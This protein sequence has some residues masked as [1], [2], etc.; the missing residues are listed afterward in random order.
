MNRRPALILASAALAAA[1]TYAL[2]RGHARLSEAAEGAPQDAGVLGLLIDDGDGYTYVPEGRYEVSH[3]I[4]TCFTCSDVDNVLEFT[5][6]PVS[7]TEFNG[8]IADHE[9]KWHASE[10]TRG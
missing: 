7:L 5:G 2:R 9:M 3:A 1:G 6:D 10:D 8:S 4:V